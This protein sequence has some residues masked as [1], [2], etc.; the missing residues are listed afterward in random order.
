VLT[1]G[2]RALDAVEKGVRVSEL[3][4]K[5]TS[6]GYGGFPD[7]NGIVSLDACIMDE[8]NNCGSVT[9][10]QHIKNPISVARMV[11]EKT[12]H[13]MLSGEGALQFALANGFEKEELLTERARQRWE[14]WKKSNMNMPVDM[15][16]HD[17]ISTL[18]IDKKGDISGAC[19][20]SGTAFKHHGRVGDSPIIGAGLYVDNE[21]GAA[22][23]TG[24]GE[25]ILK[26][27]GSHTIVEN[28]RH[29]YSPQEACEEAV[30]RALKKVP[31]A[32][33]HPI[34]FIALNKA[35]EV[36]AYGTNTAFKYALYTQESGNRLI[37]AG[38][39]Y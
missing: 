5:V 19:T 27:V 6:V 39:A 21:I 18:A 7:R 12:P 3:D 9:F 37:Q 30:Q 20:T 24:V 26:I 28:M 14:K 16:N 8:Q 2:G 13:V 11:M 33:K 36:G 4:P 22:G 10:L 31:D 32:R 38:S 23:A 1:A 35:G 17:T 29:G 25:V 15:H 34:Y